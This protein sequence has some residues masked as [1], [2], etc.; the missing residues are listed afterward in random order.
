M[1]Q[2]G[3]G[4]GL[5]ARTCAS[6][7]VNTC[8]SSISWLSLPCINEALVQPVVVVLVCSEVIP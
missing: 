7:A 4:L 1:L 6:L 5:N 3:L 2:F 8:E